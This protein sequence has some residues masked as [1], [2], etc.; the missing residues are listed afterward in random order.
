MWEVE[1]D[2]NDVPELKTYLS[3][4]LLMEAKKKP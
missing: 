4:C 3:I 2:P 1:M